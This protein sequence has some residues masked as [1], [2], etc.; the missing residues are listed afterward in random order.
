MSE[1]TASSPLPGNRRNGPSTYGDGR[2]LQRRA[3]PLLTAT[4]SP[5]GARVER[6]QWMTFSGTRAAPRTL[7]VGLWPPMFWLLGD[8]AERW[9]D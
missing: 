2:E 7:V 5:D 6:G 1:V 3:V 8:A 4:R 9:S